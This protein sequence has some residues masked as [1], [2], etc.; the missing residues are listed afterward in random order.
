M[1]RNA[2]AYL[3]FEVVVA[4]ITKACWSRKESPYAVTHT[5]NFGDDSVPLMGNPIMHT[6][7]TSATFTVLMTAT[8]FCSVPVT[9]THDI[10]IT[11]KVWYDIYMPLVLRD[12]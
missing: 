5:W 11:P 12:A 1:P 7:T 4:L 3:C 2:S 8:N 9:A 10:V 6:F